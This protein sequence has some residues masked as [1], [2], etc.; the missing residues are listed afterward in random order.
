MLLVGGFVP[1]VLAAAL[2]SRP[3]GPSWRFALPA[4]PVVILLV[5]AGFR[6]TG[7]AIT[8]T[9]VQVLRP[10]GPLEVPW[11]ALR[12]VRFP[13]V[14]PRSFVLGIFRA[15]FF[16][17]YGAYWSR[18]WGRFDLYLTNQANSV[19]LLKR[20]GRR[21]VISPGD[22]QAFLVALRATPEALGSGV[23]VEG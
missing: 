19:V 20:D 7:F 5:T 14:W 10:A 12:S 9:G 4:L 6:P 11:E 2:W 16:G 21:V 3:A 13:V 8:S 18:A 1:L 22:P 23:E 15:D 17:S